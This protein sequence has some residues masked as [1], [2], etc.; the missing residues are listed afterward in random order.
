MF[1]KT[2]CQV[3][4][5]PYGKSTNERC[6]YNDAEVEDPDQEVRLRVKCPRGKNKYVI[7]STK[8]NTDIS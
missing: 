1:V 8:S 7:A 4:E 6:R 5:C 2:H 3:A